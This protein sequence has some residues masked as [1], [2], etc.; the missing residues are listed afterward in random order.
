ML[1]LLNLFFS[2]QSEI[3]FDIETSRCLLLIEKNASSSQFKLTKTYNK[4]FKYFNGAMAIEFLKQNK[5]QEITV[6]IREPIS[7]FQS[8]LG[9][10]MKFYGMTQQTLDTSVFLTDS[11]DERK[12]SFGVPLHINL[13]DTHT[14]PQFW[15]LFRLHKSL[16]EIKF[17]LYNIDRYSLM[18]PFASTVNKNNNK[19]IIPDKALDQLDFFYT[20]DIVLFN[21]CLDSVMSFEEIVN[22]I[23]LEKEF[24]NEISNYKEILSLYC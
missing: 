19:P 6:F 11:V 7:R 8:G 9:Q 12:K 5:I 24:I 22:K 2:N 4:R 16:P 14:S 20:E 15:S 17:C 21:Q 18:Y 1:F 23:K 3:V 13:F 10:Q